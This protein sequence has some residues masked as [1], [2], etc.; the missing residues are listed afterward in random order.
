M[1]EI[2]A[3]DRNNRIATC[4]ISVGKFSVNSTSNK[5]IFYNTSTSIIYVFKNKM[6]WNIYWESTTKYILSHF[7]FSKN[8]SQFKYL[9]YTMLKYT[10]LVKELEY[11]FIQNTQ[12]QTK[13]KPK[14]KTIS[15]V[16]AWTKPS[17]NVYKT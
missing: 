15:F 11:L 12:Q 4:K 16:K 10:K 6:E 17:Q 13:E 1:K 7:T 14:K 5:Y 8:V 2:T 3:F 9:S